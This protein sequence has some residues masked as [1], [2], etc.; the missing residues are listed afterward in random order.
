[1]KTGVITFHNAHNYGASL[2][3]WAL[4]KVL[5]NLG[6]QAKVIHYHPSAIDALYNPLLKQ[7]SNKIIQWLKRTKLRK[8]VRQRY[9]KNER[10]N[11]FI[12]ETFELEGD[13]TS[14]EELLN[15]NMDFDAY[16]TGSDQVWNI[17]H[18]GGLD[19]AYFLGFAKEGVLKLSYAASIGNDQIAAEYKEDIASFLKM[20]DAISVREESVKSEIET[21]SEKEVSVVLDPTLLLQKEDYDELKK[22]YKLKEK[23]ILVYMMEENKEL[24][25]LANSISKEV[26]LP[27]IQR[28]Q[29][30]Y[31]ENEISNFY[32]CLPSEF[33][34]LVENAEY[35]ITN[36]F[37]GTVFS[38]IYKKRFVSMLHSLTGNRT[39]DL[40][41][42]LQEEKH[43]LYSEKDFK[44]FEQF[45]IEDEMK[46]D[47]LLSELRE[48]SIEF[49]V[50]SL[51]IE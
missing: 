8:S 10:Y 38:L 48:Q 12:R 49:L 4:Q 27:I 19:P 34:S 7:D 51:K 28:K 22:E 33:L 24:I 13:F 16:I 2:Q 18:T 40:L 32:E 23:Y 14:Y 46:L 44:G 47:K 41:K 3:T 25:N 21:L 37:H 9:R 6:I 17:D 35:I 31:F 42:M 26:G 11:Q 30:R 36:S 20:F 5:R 50:N 15:S 45:L 1:M 29:K 39:S 43:L